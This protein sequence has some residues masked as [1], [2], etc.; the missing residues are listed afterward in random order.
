M[1]MKLS[2]RGRWSVPFDIH[3]CLYRTGDNDFGVGKG[4]SSNFS[5]PVFPSKAASTFVSPVL[6][7]Y[8]HYL[9]AGKKKLSKP[10]GIGKLEFSAF[11]VFVGRGYLLHGGYDRDG[12]QGLCYDT[13]LKPTSYDV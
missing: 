10:L 13:Y 4:K 9:M 8:L 5:V 11:L 12:Y 3:G 6:H 7:G 1:A 2:T